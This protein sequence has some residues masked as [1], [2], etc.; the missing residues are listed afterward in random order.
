MSQQNIL[1]R[2]RQQVQN[3]N[4]GNTGNPTL[5]TSTASNNAAP[6]GFSIANGMIQTPYSQP[7]TLSGSYLS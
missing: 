1:D 4:Q 6:A 5:N 2:I 7:K 3:A